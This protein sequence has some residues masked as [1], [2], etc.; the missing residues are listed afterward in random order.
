M[1]FDDEQWLLSYIDDTQAN[2]SKI[3]FYDDY[4]LLLLS[5]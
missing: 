4:F 2:K 5:L 1:T 3:L